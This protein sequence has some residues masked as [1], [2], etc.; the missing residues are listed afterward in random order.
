MLIEKLSQSITL[1][2]LGMGT[3]F[4][5]LALLIACVTL[6]SVVCR[7]VDG[8]AIDKKVESDKQYGFHNMDGK[9]EAPLSAKLI[10][11]CVDL[12]ARVEEG[13][14]VM[15]LE[16]MKM[17]TEIRANCSGRASEIHAAVGDNVESGQT[18]LTLSTEPSRQRSHHQSGS[19]TTDKKSSSRKN[20]QMIKAPLSANVIDVCIELNDQVKEGDVIVKLE[21]MKMETEMRADSNGSVSEIHIKKGDSITAGQ[22]ILTLI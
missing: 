13:D 21:A 12:N 9:V 2:G 19:L 6:L 20:S 4:V 16:A 3:V 11:V 7:R 1:F 10:E 22:I 14:L 5:L 8:G 18:L 17:E 15:R